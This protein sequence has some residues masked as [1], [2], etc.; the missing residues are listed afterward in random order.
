[1]SGMDLDVPQQRMVCLAVVPKL[2]ELIRQSA[3][4]LK[5]VPIVP[6]ILYHLVHAPNRSDGICIEWFLMEDIGWEASELDL[7]LKMY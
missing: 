1:M 4:V 7:T 3:S 5:M 6:T 2:G